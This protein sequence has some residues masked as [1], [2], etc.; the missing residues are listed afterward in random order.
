[1][2]ELSPFSALQRTSYSRRTIRFAR[3]VVDS[4]SERVQ[5]AFEQPTLIPLTGLTSFDDFLRNYISPRICR[6]RQA[7]D[8][9]C[10]LE[11]I[12]HQPNLIGLK[13]AIL[14]QA[15]NRHVPLPWNTPHHA[16]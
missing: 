4:L 14:G 8:A 16:K 13:G 6:I 15:N 7:K 2:S 3:A 5:T 9:T 11:S 1:M 12:G 10:V